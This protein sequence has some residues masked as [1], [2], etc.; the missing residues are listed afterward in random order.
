M[1]LKQQLFSFYRDFYKWPYSNEEFAS[2]FRR[3]GQESG[4]QF[5]EKFTVRGACAPAHS[6]LK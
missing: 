2:E 1:A 4:V 5:A 3:Y 6:F